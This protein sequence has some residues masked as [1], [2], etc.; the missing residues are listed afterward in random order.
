MKN[1]L[2]WIKEPPKPILKDGMD[3]NLPGLW[4]THDPAAYRDPVSGLYYVYSTGALAKRSGDLVE[5]ESLGKVVPGVPKEASDWTGSEDIWAPD[6]VKAGEEYRLYCSNSSWGVQRSCIF[7]AVSK[8]PEGPFLPKEGGSIVLKTDDCL[9]VNGIDANI[10]EDP[11]T[12]EQFLLYG[13]FWGGCYVLPLDKESGLSKDP[14]CREW[15]PDPETGK[16]DHETGRIVGTCV[17]RRPAWM[18]GGIEGPYMVWN[19]ETGYY[20]LFVSY[21]SLKSDYNIRV[22]RSK[23]IT[24]PFTDLGGRLLTDV[25]DPDNSVGNLLMAGYTWDE[26]TAYMAPGHNSAMHDPDGQWYLF[27]HIRER[28]FTDSPEPSTMQVRRMYFSEEGWPYLAPEN[29]A[30]DVERE[31]LEEE[32]TGLYERIDFIPALP[33][34]I[35]AAAPLRLGKEGYY[36]RGSIQGKWEIKKRS[37]KGTLLKAEFGPHHE[38]LHASVI[39][40]RDRERETIGLCGIDER[41]V[42][43]WA[44]KLP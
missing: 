9:P 34:G 12:G 29:Y 19:E 1:M 8:S 14:A 26:G 39:F 31:F 32:L 43:F 35:S 30:L 5:W 3:R 37:D 20:Y 23:S 24:G 11:K 38:E 27:C 22:G 13:S 18:S 36:E 28:N 40:D 42:V 44:R 4:M 6:I 25:E 10:I 15:E 21:G 2:K 41:G 16:P 17:A 7:L 33:Q